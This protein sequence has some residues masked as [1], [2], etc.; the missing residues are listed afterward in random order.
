[1]GLTDSVAHAVESIDELAIKRQIDVSVMGVEGV[2][3]RADRRALQHVLI[4]LL[5]NAVRYTQEGGQV[6][7]TAEPGI[8]MVRIEISDNGPGIPDKYH[9]RIFERFFRVDKGRSTHMG[10]TGLGLS[11][12]KHLVGNMGGDVGVSNNSPQG[13]VFWFTLPALSEAEGSPA[14]APTV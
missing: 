10:G 7:L 3:V 4:N 9:K 11:I 13:A 8:G 2:I 6:K 12:V 1:M 14:A 5:Q